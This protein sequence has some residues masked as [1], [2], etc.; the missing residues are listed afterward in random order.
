MFDFDCF[1]RS[2]L[3]P[4]V[5]ACAILVPSVGHAAG[6]SPFDAT[7]AQKKDATDHFM[8]GKRALE[9]RN[10]DKAVAELRA[11]LQIVDSPNARLELARALR[12]S[13]HLGDAWAEY[14]RAAE[15]A[16]RLAP[17]EE[18]YAKTA[19]AA[20]SER[21]ELARKLAFIEV[22]VT[23]A[24]VDVTLNVGGHIVPSDDW[25]GPL[26]V[27]PGSVDVVLTNGAGVELAR[28]SVTAAIGQTAPVTL[29][30]EPSPIAKAEVEASDDD[31]TDTSDRTPPQPAVSP[32]N[33]RN[34]RPYAYVAGAI[35]VAGLATFTV[36]GLLS[37]S[38][39]DDLKNACPRGCPPSKRSEIDRGSL[40]Q[41]IANVGLGVG[42]VGLAAGTTMFFLSTS[43]NTP[44]AATAIIVG[45]GYL[46]V[47]GAL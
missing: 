20:T 14:W 33:R 3:A 9:S 41:T 16:T 10:L 44:T 18:R 22:T 40:E 28:R 24:P 8:V 34:L 46:A 21:E 1:V 36:L 11:S 39:Y 37:N 35:G 43:G 31:K 42:L 26:V 12:D 4:C 17:K 5:L 47:R 25:A 45:P 13:D 19:E 29:D 7:P 2:V 32:S 27:A 30:A 6:V 38:T 15:T 23:H